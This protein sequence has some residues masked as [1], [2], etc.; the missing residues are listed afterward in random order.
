M[1]KIVLAGDDYI[2]SDYM[3][4]GFLPFAEKGYELVKTD[5]LWGGM[6]TMSE[7]NRIVEEQGP[8]AVAPHADADTD[9]AFVASLHELCFQGAGRAIFQVYAF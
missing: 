7:K 1:K 2:G 5:W 9:L 3:Y 4:D 8:E 6:E